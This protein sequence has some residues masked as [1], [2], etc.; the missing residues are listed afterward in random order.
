MAEQLRAPTAHKGPG[1]GSQ[2]PCRSSQWPT[3]LVPEDLMPSTGLCMHVVC[4]YIFRHAHMH[5]S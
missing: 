4:I 5:I 3:T 2:H 1:F